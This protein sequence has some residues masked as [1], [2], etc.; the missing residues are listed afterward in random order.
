[1]TRYWKRDVNADP[2]PIRLH[3]VGRVAMAVL[4]IG[5]AFGHMFGWL[6]DRAIMDVLAC[7]L[8]AL[9]MQKWQGD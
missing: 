3:N 1:M 5:C 6:S 4:L 9:M 8:A 2:K 7:G